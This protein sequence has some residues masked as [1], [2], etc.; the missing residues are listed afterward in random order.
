M[1]TKRSALT[2][3]LLEGLTDEEWRVVRTAR[4][5]VLFI[6]RRVSAKR[7]VEALRVPDLGPD[8]GVASGCTSGSATCRTGGN[9][10]LAGAW[11]D[12]ARRSAPFARLVAGHVRPHTCDQ[13]RSAA[14]ASAARSRHIFGDSLL[15]TERSLLSGQSHTDEGCAPESAKNRT[16]S[17]RIR[18]AQR[19]SVGRLRKSAS[20]SAVSAGSRSN[21]ASIV[22]GPATTRSGAICRSAREVLNQGNLKDDCPDRVRAGV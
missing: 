18:G 13:H 21:F 15:S 8:P 11:R 4:A 12:G 19:Q 5:N 9:I 6:G 3:R 17:T 22:N 14:Y 20:Y 10:D 1:T 16:A 2:R 7:V